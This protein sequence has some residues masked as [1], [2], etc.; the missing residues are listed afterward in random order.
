MQMIKLYWVE[1]GQ[2]MSVFV[3][4]VPILIYYEKVVIWIITVCAFFSPAKAFQKIIWRLCPNEVQQLPK[5]DEKV[6]HLWWFLLLF[7]QTRKHVV[8]N[9]WVNTNTIF[10]QMFVFY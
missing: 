7:M 9:L 1:I 2:P 6:R 5:E 4:N 3:C 8:R 10:I